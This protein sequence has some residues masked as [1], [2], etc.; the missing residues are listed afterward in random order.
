MSH[1]K[2]LYTKYIK[3]QQKIKERKKRE[4]KLNIV[5]SFY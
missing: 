2:C 5:N 1:L 3:L 4:K